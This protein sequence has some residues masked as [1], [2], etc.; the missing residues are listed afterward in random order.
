MSLPTAVE[1]FSQRARAARPGADLP[2]EAVAEV[3]RHLDGLP[4]AVE[5][6]A[7]RVRVLSVAEIARRLEDRFGLLRGGARDAPERHQT[8]Q[9]VVDWSWNLLEPAGRAAL[10]V[11]PAGS[12]TT[13]PGARRRCG[14]GRHRDPGGPRRPVA[15]PGGGH[16]GRHE[17]PDAGDGTRVQHGAPRGGRGD[18]P[19]GRRVPGLGPRLRDGAPRRGLR[20][21]PRRAAA[22]DPGRAGQPRAGAPAR[23][24]PGG[25]RRRRGHVRRAREPVDHRVHLPAPGDARLRD[26]PA[27]VALP[28]RSTSWRP[29]GRPWHCP[30]PTRSSSR[31]PV[32]CARWSPCAGCRR[33]RRTPWSEPSRPC[34]RP[35]PRTAALYGLCDSD[36]P[37]VA[38][39][40]SGV[41]SYFWENEVTW[42]RPEGGPADA[43]R[44]RAAQAPYLGPSPTP[45]S[46]SRARRSSG[47][48]RPCATCWRSCRCWS[49]SRDHATWPG[50]RLVLANPQVGDV[51]EA[52]Q[53]PEQTAPPHADEPVGALTYGLGRAG[54]DPARGVGADQGGQDLHRGGLAAVATSRSTPSSTTCSPNDLRSPATA[55]AVRDGMVAMLPSSRSGGPGG[56]DRPEHARSQ[57]QRGFTPVSAGRAQGQAASATQ[58]AP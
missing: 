48:T 23:P 2:A 45:A 10:S 22:A 15:A 46:A 5:L 42:T 4:L 55:I 13:P 49:S 30:P 33:P 11:F 50:R 17:V 47:V 34:W 29:P 3:C 21:R 57:V 28:A 26:R 35:P 25:R 54:R 39:A 24:R 43:R 16:P 1:L 52:E 20:D 14:R 36:E 56:H 6:A 58:T 18:R 53:L 51:D 19:G 31:G 12:P 41:V 27:A 8:L 7:A 40:A 44:L 37:L 32:R 38:G 9:A